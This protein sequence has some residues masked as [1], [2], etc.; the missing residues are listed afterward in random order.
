MTTNKPTLLDLFLGH[1]TMEPQP[2][3]TPEP[4]PT[5]AKEQ[6]YKAPSRPMTE[7]EHRLWIEHRMMQL[8]L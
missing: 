5:P 7:R 1:A 3:P 2:E 6:G 4:A 8:R